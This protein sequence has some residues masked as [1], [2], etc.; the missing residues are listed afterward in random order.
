MG[1]ALLTFSSLFQGLSA[2]QR[3]A[4]PAT[5]VRPVINRARVFS[6][7]RPARAGQPFHRSARPLD[8]SARPAHPAVSAPLRVVRLSEGGER[9]GSAGRMVIS[10]RMADVC[11]EL[12]RLA[13]REVAAQGH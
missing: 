2:L 7:G 5:T 13:A 8:L 12:D 9:P 10:G 3:V 4:T 1:I 6:S 11:A